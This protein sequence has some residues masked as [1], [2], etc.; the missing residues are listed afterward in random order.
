MIVWCEC[1][2]GGLEAIIAGRLEENLF[3]ITPDESS[4]Q[5]KKQRVYHWDKR[6][7]KYVKSSLTELSENQRGAK[8][9]RTES[10]ASIM[11][12]KVCQSHKYYDLNTLI[13]TS[14][15]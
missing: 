11:T 8:K 14:M 1:I 15:N 12:K 6:K 5:W 3:D 2:V 4:E 7:K 9:L 13:I 10:G